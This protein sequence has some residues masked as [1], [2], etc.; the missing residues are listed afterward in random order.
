MT[1]PDSKRLGLDD[2]IEMWRN[3]IVEAYPG[4]GA[5]M[6][7]DYTYGRKL[8]SDFGKAPHIQYDIHFL[9]ILDHHETLADALLDRPGLCLKGLSIAIQKELEGRS[10][11]SMARGLE[12]CRITVNLI[13][14]GDE[15]L[16]RLE[17]LRDYHINRLITVVVNIIAVGPPETPYA[18]KFFHCGS[19]E[20]HPNRISVGLLDQAKEPGICN[21]RHCKSTFFELVE[22]RCTHL[23]SQLIQLQQHESDIL[24]QTPEPIDAYLTDAMVGLKP[25]TNKPITLHCIWRDKLIGTKARARHYNYLEV[26]GVEETTQDG[27]VVTDEHREWARRLVED[28]KTDI[29]ELL[30]NSICPSVHG[31]KGIKLALA[32]QAAGGANVIVGG[33]RLRGLLHILLFGDPSVA[34]SDLM[35]CMAR[36]TPNSHFLSATG[37]SG[38]GLTFAMIE[39]KITGKWTAQPGIISRSNNGTAVVDEMLLL[40]KEDLDR[41][42]EAFERGVISVGKAGVF[43]TLPAHTSILGGGNREKGRID[44]DRPASEQLKLHPAILSRFDLIFVIIDHPEAERDR[45]ILKAVLRRKR[46]QL[47][48][49]LE[50]WTLLTEEQLLIYF[51]ICREI[52]VEFPEEL[53]EEVEK[54]YLPARKID[55]HGF[56]I[57]PRQILTITKLAEANARLQLRNIVVKEDLKVAEQLFVL[58]QETQ[59]RVLW[60]IHPDIDSF[61][62]AHSHDDEQDIRL[63]QNIIHHMGGVV[64]TKG[65]DQFELHREVSLACQDDDRARRILGK[66]ESLG[67]IILEGGRYR[68]N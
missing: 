59:A 39:N 30:V 33:A 36:V 21:D 41:T 23:S 58:S 8:D 61:I 24:A 6:Q 16:V 54:I 44:P 40:S 62:G 22:D 48:Q 5:D 50:T 7:K 47:P 66:M 11:E 53:D 35:E 42:R 43:I 15:R 20:Q 68:F 4:Q 19:S 45:A 26:V 51:T 28:E 37:A 52:E 46:Q 49:D 3:F 14:I 55:T 38:P 56:R 18:I 31:L 1:G 13:G 17:D 34:K 29:L 25:N 67:K 2:L 65:I 9:D 63:F 60:G 32:L 12:Q 57:T 10:E 27:F 64:R